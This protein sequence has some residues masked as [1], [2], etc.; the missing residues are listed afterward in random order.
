M[1]AWRRREWWPT[2]RC[3]RFCPDRQR[4][5]P[6]GGGRGAVR[7][8]ATLAR[9]GAGPAGCLGGEMKRAAEAARR[10]VGDLAD[11]LRLDLLEAAEGVLTIVNSNMA[12][13]IRSRTIQKGIDPRRFSLVAFGGAG[14]LHGVEVAAMLEIPEVIVPLYPGLTS[15]LG[16]LTTA[17][18]YD[19]GRTEC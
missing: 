8:A 3:S 10:A 19:A 12:N 14:P 6:A 4:G 17:L 18:K 9:G 2:S 13:A 7:P 16:L 11:R 5:C 1:A 15:A